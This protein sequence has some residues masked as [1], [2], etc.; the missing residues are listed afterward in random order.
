LLGIAALSFACDDLNPHAF[1]NHT[2]Q[3]RTRLEAGLS[4]LKSE[5]GIQ[6]KIWGQDADRISNTSRF[7]FVGFE[8]YENWVELLDLRGF[9]ISHGSACKSKIIEPSRVL[10]KMGASR[11]EALNAIRVS[12]GKDTSAADVDDFIMA[13]RSILSEKR[14]RP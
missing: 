8:G 12:L 6:I 4:E 5:T 2:A 9:A 3:L 11:S 14:G 10:L 7:S 1:A 13:I